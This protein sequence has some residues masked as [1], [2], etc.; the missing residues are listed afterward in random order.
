[1]RA[2]RAKAASALSNDA[3]DFQLRFAM[4]RL[5]VILAVVLVALGAVTAGLAALHG[6]KPVARVEKVVP[7]ASLQK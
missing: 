6:E 3:S 5:I 1:M 2:A 7:L 4:S